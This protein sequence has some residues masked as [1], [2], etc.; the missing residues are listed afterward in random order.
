MVLFTLT[1]FPNSCSVLFNSATL[2]SAR[3]I[4]SE[5]RF[6]LLFRTFNF[7]STFESSSLLLETVISNLVISSSLFSFL[8][9]K[10]AFVSSFILIFC[11]NCSFSFD[12]SSIC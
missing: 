10:E 4:S 3:I 1:V 6:E 9:I 5:R 2:F 12:N 11:C 7:S 8:I